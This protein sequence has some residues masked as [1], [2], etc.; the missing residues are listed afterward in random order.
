MG[1]LLSVLR[2]DTGIGKNGYTCAV[3]TPLREVSV[4]EQG[5]GYIDG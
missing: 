2:D 3:A 1:E 4:R 5:I